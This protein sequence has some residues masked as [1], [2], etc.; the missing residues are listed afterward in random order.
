MST[1]T[2][3]VSH[4]QSRPWIPVLA[5]VAAALLAGWGLLHARTGDGASVNLGDVVQPGAASG[6]NLLLVTLDTTRPGHLGCYGYDLAHTPTIDRLAS[7]GVL[8]TDAVTSVPLTLPSHATILTGQYPARLGVGDNGQRVA[9][10]HT[11]LAEIL[12]AQGYETAAFVGSFVLDQRWGLAQGFDKYDFSIAED[13]R[14]GADSLMSERRANEVSNAALKWLRERDASGRDEPFFAWLHYYDPHHPYDSPLRG[15]ERFSGRKFGDYD[16]EITLADMHLGRVLEALDKQGLT[17]RTLIVFTTDHGEGFYEK[18]EAYHG[19]FVYETTMHAALVFSNP[20]LFAS[21]ARVTDRVAGTVDIVPT[22]LDLLGVPASMPFDGISLVRDGGDPDRAIYIETRFPLANAC[23]PL[24]GLRRHTDKYILAPRPEFYDLVAD[25]A[26]EEN[27]HD[28]R[29]D[30]VAELRTRLEDWRADMSSTGA[31][32]A[33]VSALSP[34]EQKRL[35]GLG[36]AGQ[37]GIVDTGDLPDPKD[38]IEVINKMSEVTHLKSVERYDE[39]IA[40]AQAVL[41]ESPCWYAPVKNLAEMYVDTDQP[42]MAAEVFQDFLDRCREQNAVTPEALYHYAT[43]TVH[44]LKK[45]RKAME[46]ADEALL[47]A[48]DFGAAHVVRG[49]AHAAMGNLDLAIMEYQ[50]A[51]EVDPQRAGPEA[52]AKLKAAQARR[53]EQ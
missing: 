38:Q 23:S 17:E 1:P 52:S 32:A 14:A 12:K 41:A 11:T 7:H 22:V 4:K 50:T 21:A 42:E 46:L 27:L 43:L 25:P 2:P 16:A 15:Q 19:I 34:E 37:S 18:Q 33:Q 13:G 40:L 45:P 36:Y 29:P 35:E 49:D 10:E 20:T 28:E 31:A 47:L 9:E 44:R 5:L 3:A 24:Y 53:A 39:G 6:Y 48:K 30:V 8:F 26:E 51:L